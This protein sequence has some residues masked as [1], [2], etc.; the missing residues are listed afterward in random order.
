[1][2]GQT[3]S[4]GKLGGHCHTKHCFLCDLFCD[5]GLSKLSKLVWL[6]LAGNNLTNLD[7]GV[8]EKLPQLRFL[9]VENNAITYLRGLQVSWCSCTSVLA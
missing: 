6:S 4:V 2:T 5:T 8:L 9:S 1:M 3:T 7:T